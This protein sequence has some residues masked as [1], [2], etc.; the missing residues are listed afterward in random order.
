M[1]QTADTS[2]SGTYTMTIRYTCSMTSDTT[3]FTNDPVATVKAYLIKV[4]TQTVANMEHSKSFT[5]DTTAT[6]TKWSISP[7]TGDNMPSYS[8][9]YKLFASDET[10]AA[11]AWLT[12]DTSAASTF[13]ITINKATAVVGTYNNMV[14][15]AEVKDH[16]GTGTGKYFTEKFNVVVYELLSTPVDDVVYVVDASNT[17]E[18][19]TFGAFTCPHCPASLLSTLTYSLETSGA[20]PSDAL[21]TYASWLKSLTQATRKVEFQS[22]DTSLAGQYTLVLKGSISS[23]PATTAT[24]SFKVTLIALQA[25]TQA[26]I[27]YLFKDSPPPAKAIVP[28]TYTASGATFAAGPTW[29][30]SLAHTSGPTN[31]ATLDASSNVLVGDVTSITAGSVSGAITDVTKKGLTTTFTLTGQLS[32]AVSG[33]VLGAAGSIA[34]PAR[35]KASTT[36]KVHIVDFDLTTNDLTIL[37][38]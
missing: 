15:R 13:A 10:T 29:T 21:T 22:S 36:F 20:T 33:Q 1:I 32:G 23:S 25:P 4:V 35:A 12:I 34:I 6:N 18:S 11:P 7:S 2:L 38:G 19:I 3:N 26:D 16:T 8:L 31:V 9:E 37:V 27:T 30:Y 17:L 14:V 24:T 5:T 28:F